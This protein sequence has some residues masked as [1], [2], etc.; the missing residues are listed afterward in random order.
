L[1]FRI[2]CRR[3][4]FE[5]YRA[6]QCEY[7]HF[8]EPVVGVGNSKIGAGIISFSIPPDTVLFTSGRVVRTCPG[9][10]HWC[11]KNCYA[12]KNLMSLPR[13]VSLYASNLVLYLELGPSRFAEALERKLKAVQARRGAEKTL[14]IH[15]AGDMFDK[16]YI[17][18]WRHLAERMPDWRFYTY[19]RSWRVPELLP[20]LEKLRRLPNFVVY[21]STDPDTGPPPQGWLEACCVDRNYK[22]GFEPYTKTVRC[23]EETRGLVCAEC[24]ICIMGRSSVRW[25]VVR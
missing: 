18:V 19:T 1:E 11:R 3:V 8:G 24:R 9:A 20:Y 4:E 10:T 25:E 12:K 21:A 23:P 7:A 2:I 5:G 15:V 16:D 17:E 22:R 14:R 13:Q 6:F